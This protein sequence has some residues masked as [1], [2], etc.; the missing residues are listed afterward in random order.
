MR[1]S[2][3]NSLKTWRFLLV[4]SWSYLSINGTIY[5]LHPGDSSTVLH[6]TLKDALLQILAKDEYERNFISAVVPPNEI[7][8]KFDDI[9]ALEDVKKTLD[10]LVTLPMR[11]PEL[12]SHGNLLR[13]WF[14]ATQTYKYVSHGTDWHI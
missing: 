8:V 13:V 11:R 14:A 3:S 5:F 6:P 7:G 10:E 12:F 2:I 1:H 4:V 9:G